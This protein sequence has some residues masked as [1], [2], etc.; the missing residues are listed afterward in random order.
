MYRAAEMTF[1]ML[2]HQFDGDL[3]IVAFIEEILSQAGKKHNRF[4]F[5]HISRRVCVGFF[6]A[7]KGRCTL[8]YVI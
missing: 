2:L 1:Y 5:H 4:H 7:K 8:F 6:L 3:G